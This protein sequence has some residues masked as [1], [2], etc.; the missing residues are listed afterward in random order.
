MNQFQKS[1]HPCDGGWLVYMLLKGHVRPV[2]AD[3]GNTNQPII[4]IV[5]EKP[6]DNP[7][8]ELLI[9]YIHAFARL[10]TIYVGIHFDNLIVSPVA[11]VYLLNV[12]YTPTSHFPLADPG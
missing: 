7:L 12:S 11:L 4:E 9:Y 6:I 2:H 1:C 5:W 8:N 3:A 10:S